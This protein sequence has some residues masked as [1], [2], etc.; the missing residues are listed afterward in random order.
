MFF[1]FSPIII[2]VLDEVCVVTERFLNVTHV[3]KLAGWLKIVCLC[4][5]TGRKGEG[6]RCMGVEGRVVDYQYLFAVHM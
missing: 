2:L 5:L 6:G 4:G 3:E 1:F